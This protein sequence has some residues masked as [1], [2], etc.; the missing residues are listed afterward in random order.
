MGRQLEEMEN[1]MR[2]AIVHVYI[3]RSAEVV[4]HLRRFDGGGPAD[5]PRR[6]LQGGLAA[7]LAARGARAE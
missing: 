7:A 3:G 1:R 6:E 2:D 5:G 4:S